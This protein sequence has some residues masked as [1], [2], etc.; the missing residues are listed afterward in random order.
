[1]N[2][3]SLLTNSLTSD[4]S[5]NS[6]SQATG[7]SQ[8]SNQSVVSSALPLLMQA[9]TNNAS[10][11]SGA[12]SLLGALTQHTSTQPVAQQIA[13]ADTDDGAKIL[14]HIFGKNV[15]SVYSQ[16]A[17]ETGTSSSDV[18]KILSYLAPTLL[19]S[20]SSATTTAAQAQ[21]VKPQ[22]SGFN[23][24]DG[25]GMNDVMGLLGNAV[26]SNS[27]SNNSSNASA[28]S[29]LAGALLG[30]GNSSSSSNNNNGA[31]LL[32]SL[33]GSMLK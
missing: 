1:M 31:A 25:F 13:T 24:A 22:A 30:G 20:L 9:L 28:L 10:T 29:S 7:I 33:L 23:L 18:K 19:S 11:Q 17:K 4:S 32:T 15:K 26:A 14:E 5:L 16:I 2:L 12:Q 6:L 27:N 21:N 8:Q 3:L